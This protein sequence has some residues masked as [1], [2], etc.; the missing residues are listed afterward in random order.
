MSLR[1]LS[2]LML[3]SLVVSLGCEAGDDATDT[4]TPIDASQP[5][6]VEPAPT[7]ADGTTDSP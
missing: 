1:L 3:L 7:G 5:D 6:A 2:C 4:T